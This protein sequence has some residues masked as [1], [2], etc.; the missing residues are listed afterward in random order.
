MKK[1]IFLFALLLMAPL[2][3]FAQVFPGDTTT[4]IHIPDNIYEVLDNPGLFMKQ[5]GYLAGFVWFLTGIL[6]LVFKMTSEK[7]WP[8]LVLAVV[9]AVILSAVT[10][11][12]NWGLFADSAWL[13]TILGGLGI[14]LVAGGVSDI[15]TMKIALNIILSLI[16]LK[17]PTV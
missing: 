2:L 11:L 15:S 5:V 3:L 6:V 10:N 7:K 13:D 12:A 17:K 1:L 8:K 9:I 4:V 16:R 14:G